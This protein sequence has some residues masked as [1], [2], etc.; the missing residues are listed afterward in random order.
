MF[1]RHWCTNGPIHKFFPI[2]VKATFRITWDNS[3][4]TWCC[5]IIVG[6]NF[7][8]AVNE[9]TV[10]QYSYRAISPHLCSW[11]RIL[12]V[13]V[14]DSPFLLIVIYIFHFS[15]QTKHSWHF[16]TTQITIKNKLNTDS[17]SKKQQSAK[18]SNN[19]NKLDGD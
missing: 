6:W 3:R 17:S 7:D 9:N 11:L 14:C 18:I 16:C 4:R 2:C 19:K 10:P 12:C 15:T 8:M 5:S 1:N 13:C